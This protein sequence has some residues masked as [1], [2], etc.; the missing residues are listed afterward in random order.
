MYLLQIMETIL[1]KATSE[2]A[3]KFYKFSETFGDVEH[4]S[5][6][7]RFTAAGNSFS[8][9]VLRHL[10]RVLATLTYGNESRMA[11]L[12]AHFAPVLDLNAFDAEHGPEDE[13]R[14]EL[15]CILTSAIERNAIGNTFKDH[16]VSLGIVNRALEYITVCTHMV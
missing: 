2:S 11:P 15:F 7:L 13:A 9:S 14:L 5:A 6:L 10:M 4:I 16:I 8:P 3:E 1:S 12:I